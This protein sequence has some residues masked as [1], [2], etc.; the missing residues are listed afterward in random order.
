MWN[1]P[2]VPSA[3]MLNVT[4]VPGTT[5]VIAVGVTGESDT[6][7]KIIT[8]KFNVNGQGN[9]YFEHGLHNYYTLTILEHY[10]RNCFSWMKAYGCTCYLRAEMRHPYTDEIKFKASLHSVAFQSERHV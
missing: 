10:S 2:P 4:G 3:L 8:K 7:V 9:N 1:S 5:G 6:A